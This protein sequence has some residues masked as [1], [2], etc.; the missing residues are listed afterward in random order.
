MKLHRKNVLIFK[1]LHIHIFVGK[2]INF[3]FYHELKFSLGLKFLWQNELRK[4]LFDRNNM[5]CVN[6]FINKMCLQFDVSDIDEKTC[7]SKY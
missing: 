2:K 4:L 3:L 1:L 6:K 7:E 5:S